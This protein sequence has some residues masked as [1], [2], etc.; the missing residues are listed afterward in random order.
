MKKD[1]LVREVSDRLQCSMAK[2]ERFV[3]ATMSSI[4][5]AL[6]DGDEVILTNMGILTTRV[7]KG[8]VR[9]NAFTKEKRAVPT[10]RRMKIR[11]FDSFQRDLTQKMGV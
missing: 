6:L 1:D 5:E 3:D 9:K 11:T 2:A 7:T 10:R 4:R 8:R